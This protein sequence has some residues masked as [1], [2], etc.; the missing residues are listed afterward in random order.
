MVRYSGP[1]TLSGHRKG[2]VPKEKKN[3]FSK[4]EKK[5]FHMEIK[6]T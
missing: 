1:E 2:R 4:L 3:V 5:S 6:E